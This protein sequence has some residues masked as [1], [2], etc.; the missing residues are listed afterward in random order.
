[1]GIGLPALFVCLSGDGMYM[2]LYKWIYMYIYIYIYIYIYVYIYIYMYVLHTC[3]YTYIFLYNT[4]IYTF[5]CK[6]IRTYIYT[7][8]YS[9]NTYIHIY[10]HHRIYAYRWDE[11][12]IFPDVIIIL[13]NCCLCSDC[14]AYY[15]IYTVIMCVGVYAYRCRDFCIFVYIRAH[16]HIC[17]YPSSTLITPLLHHF[18][19]QGNAYIHSDTFIIPLLHFTPLLHPYHTLKTPL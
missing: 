10:I 14:I 2:H 5:I 13:R 15:R 8:I 9:Y 6:C 12:S 4:Y 3:V 19:I 7:Y 16:V 11:K 17:I 18:R 1:L